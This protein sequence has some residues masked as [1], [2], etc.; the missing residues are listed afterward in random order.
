MGVRVSE[1]TR[2]EHD[3]Q[4]LF[5]HD[6][7]C[8]QQLML[9]SHPVRA[10]HNVILG[11]RFTGVGGEEKRKEPTTTNRDTQDPPRPP[12]VSRRLV[13]NWPTGYTTTAMRLLRLWFM[14]ELQL[15]QGAAWSLIL[16]ARLDDERRSNSFAV[17]KTEGGERPLAPSIVYTCAST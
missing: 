1:G 15:L 12:P 9:C 14:H 4:G 10:E 6:N 2:P 8:H 17:P 3:D 11:G 16:I 7:R 13:P 5:V